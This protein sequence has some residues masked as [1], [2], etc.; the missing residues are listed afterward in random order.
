L[1]DCLKCL[2]A[3]NTQANNGEKSFITLTTDVDGF[4]ADSSSLPGVGVFG[5]DTS[6]HIIVP[7]LR[8][9]VKTGTGNTVERGRISRYIQP[10]F[11]KTNKISI[12]AFTFFFFKVA[13]SCTVDLLFDWFGLACFE[14]KNKNCHLSYSLLQSSQTG[15]QR[16]SDTY[17]L[18]IP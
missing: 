7:F 10:P 6:T 5:T 16:Y 3:Y 8:K 2:L 9:E 4:E 12:F 11:I 17:P 18:S 14:N 1:I 13:L 15:G